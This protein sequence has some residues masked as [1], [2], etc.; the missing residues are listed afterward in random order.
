MKYRTWLPLAIP[1]QPTL[2]PPS[3]RILLFPSSPLS[4]SCS[5]LPI[6]VLRFPNLAQPPLPSSPPRAASAPASCSPCAPGTYSRS[7][8]RKLCLELEYLA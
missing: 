2:P 6:S 1:N 7:I 5:L 3:H 8:G 4:P